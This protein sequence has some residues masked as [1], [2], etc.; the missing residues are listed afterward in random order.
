[1]GKAHPALVEAIQRDTM[2][3]VAM[4]CRDLK[5][6]CST[7]NEWLICLDA[8]FSNEGPLVWNSFLAVMG[9]DNDTMRAKMDAAK[10]ER[11]K[12]RGTEGKDPQ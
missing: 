3:L 6:V 4:T 9:A 12:A 7:E 8:M 11:A 10:M 1:M 5:Y 2:N